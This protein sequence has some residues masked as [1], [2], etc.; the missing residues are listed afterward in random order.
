MSSQ[1]DNKEEMPTIVFKGDVKGD[2]AIVSD[3]ASVLAA[4]KTAKTL[5][6]SDQHATILLHL[7]R[8]AKSIKNGGPGDDDNTNLMN[9]DEEEKAL[10]KL[11]LVPFHK[12]DLA[13]LPREDPT[14]YAIEGKGS[15]DEMAS[16]TKQREQDERDHSSKV[17]SFLSKFNWR[18]TS[19]SGAEYSYHEAN[20]R[21]NTPQGTGD[22]QEPVPKRAKSDTPSRNTSLVDETEGT[23]SAFK[24]ELI[25]PA[26]ERQV[27]RAMPSPGMAMV[28]E[29][30][31]IYESVTK[32][33]IDSIVSSGSLSW[34][35]NIV[36]VKKEKERLLYNGNEW[37]LNVDT[38]WRTHPD[39][40]TVPRS[41]WYKHDSV[42]ELYCLGILKADGVATLRD[43]TV[44]HHLPVLREMIKHGP[45]VIEEIYGVKA[46]QLRIFVH[47]Q[48]Q[49]YQFHVHF[50]RLENDTGCQVERAHLLSDI[51]QNLESDPEFYR[52]R[53]MVYKLSVQDKLYNL[54]ETHQRTSS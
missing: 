54:I 4:A 19:E 11:T 17:T 34:L 14:D 27:S 31:T 22:M 48:P 9:E 12:N 43:L 38:K 40:S 25:Y 33:F 20:L 16:N 5:T 18:M 24:A 7:A 39:A 15:L 41:E 46:D 52:K 2:V 23:H 21:P 37:I 32:P 30:P 50:T 53:T 51:I 45:K 28:Y 1:K 44:Q 8:P 13:C 49:F 26:S 47:Y 35:H 6:I 29:T 36:Q 3:P 42:A 10:L